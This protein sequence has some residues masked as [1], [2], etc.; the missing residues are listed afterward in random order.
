M[1]WELILQLVITSIIAPCFILATKEAINWLKLKSDGVA[2]ENIRNA[3]ND[4]FDNLEKSVLLAV[5][6]TEQTF[7]SGLKAEGQFDTDAAKQ[8]AQMA[9]DKTKAIMSNYAMETIE[10]A[11]G[12]L[13]ERIRARI[14]KAIVTDE[15]RSW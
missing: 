14:E 4:A 9:L 1:D 6:E 2:D 10:A 11:T 8:A 12:T 13:E 3:L 7:V 15:L 5:A